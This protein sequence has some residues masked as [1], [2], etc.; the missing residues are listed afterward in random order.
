MDIFHKDQY[1]GIL[2]QREIVIKNV[3]DMNHLES[4]FCLSYLS[5]KLSKCKKIVN[6]LTSITVQVVI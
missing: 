2:F 5:D 1:L 3:P 6:C 4:L